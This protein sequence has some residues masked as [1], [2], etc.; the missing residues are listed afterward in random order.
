MRKLIA[1]LLLLLANP[2]LAQ[3]PGGG[4]TPT[5]IGN[6]TIMSN[7]SGAAANPLPNTLTG[8]ID[9][10]IGSTRGALLMRGASGWALLVPSSTSGQVLTSNGTGADPTY[11]TVSG[12]GTMAANTIKCNP[13]GSTAAAQ[14]CTTVIIAMANKWFANSSPPNNVQRYGDR[15]FIGDAANYTALSSFA[16]GNDWF[17]NFEGTTSNG[18]PAYAGFT[19][20]LVE[21]GGTNQTAASNLAILG[22][23]QMT[24]ASGSAAGLGT[25]GFAVNNNSGSSTSAWG[26][27]SEC[28]QT[29]NNS[30]GCI[31]LELDVRSAVSGY[32]L[33]PD[34]FQQGLIVGLQNA[35]GAEISS[36]STFS[37][38]A[39]IQI[40]PNGGLFNAGIVIFS[41]SIN[42]G[43]GS[44]ISAISM[45][46]TYHINWFSSSG[47]IAG[48]VYVGSG[49]RLNLDGSAGITH[50]GT[51]GITC[52]A[53]INT[54]TF[55]SI[56]GIVT[57]C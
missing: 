2:A 29:V 38:G 12:S 20:L 43:S 6:N 54:T 14:D 30:G 45:P 24:N 46:T 39:A 16:C 42:T 55:R 47:N 48:G 7:I 51:N 3:F 19:Q 17:S 21:A 15:F 31:A 36:P 27:Y 25:S 4:Q 18:C 9:S 22:A 23:V 49:G 50:N 44:S 8:I 57:T 26:M 33:N 10:A 53:G 32:A 28:H 34:P 40:L 56:N 52:A 41:G 37:C 5:T 11:Q 35:C 1:L 13:T